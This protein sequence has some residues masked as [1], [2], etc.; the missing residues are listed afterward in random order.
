LA[1][2]VWHCYRRPAL[3]RPLVAAV[4]AGLLAWFFS[5]AN[6]M[7]AAARQPLMPAITLSTLT[8]QP[9]TLPSLALGKPAVVNLWAS[10]CGPCRQEMPVLAAAQARDTDIA[11]IFVNQGEHAGAAAPY[12]SQLRPALSNVLLDPR[13]QLGKAV[14]SSALPTTLFYDASGKL[15]DLHLGTLSEATLA[16]SLQRLRERRPK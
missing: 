2:G 9:A 16:S 6:T 7:L 13:A 8:G 10:W 4:G 5:G 14:G 11:Y 12:L 1:V 15:V 3:R